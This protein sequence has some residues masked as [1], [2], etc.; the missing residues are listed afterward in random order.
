MKHLSTLSLSELR[1]LELQVQDALKT[2]HYLEISKAREQILHIAQSAG[3]SVD[4]I[5]ASKATKHV[6]STP[7]AA[8]YRN[9][10]DANKA[11]SGRGR[12]PFWIKAW[13]ESGKSLADLCI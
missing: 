12:Q 3:L 6:K 1:T 5:L 9:P 4:D 13:I 11:W 8:K 2:R 10:D 7:V